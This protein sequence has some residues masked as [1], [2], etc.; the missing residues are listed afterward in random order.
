[1]SDVE[2]KLLKIYDGSKPVDEELFE[3]SHINQVA[4]T[5]AVVFAGLVI[6]LCIAL[7]N[8]ENQRHALM[9]NK[10]ADPLFKRELDRKCLVTVRSRDHW[11]EHLGYAMTHLTQST[12]T[13]K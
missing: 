4:W 11:W 3:T 9:T 2:Q 5:L 7:V 12:P 1:M 8:A 10:C 13:T 6:W